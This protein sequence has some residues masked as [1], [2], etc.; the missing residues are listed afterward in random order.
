LDVVERELKSLVSHT[1]EQLDDVHDGDSATVG[2]IVTGLKR[3][4]DKKNKTMARVVLEDYSGTFNVMV[5]SRTFESHGSLLEDEARL[6]ISG[7]V[8]AREGER[9]TIIAEDI[10]SLDAAM[11]DLDVHVQFRDREAEAKLEEVR[12]L[13]EAHPGRSRVVF[14][15]LSQRD[16][17]GNP[18][19]VRLKNTNVDPDPDLVVALRDV[20]GKNAVWLG[21]RRPVGVHV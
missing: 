4:F 17:D 6:L 13:L 1:A 5:F 11:R 15:V 8:Q 12:K 21:G 14:Y 3:Q 10:R 18:L 2:G 9:A 20:V 19:R 7:R 16:A